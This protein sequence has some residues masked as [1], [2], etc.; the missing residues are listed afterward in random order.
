MFGDILN[1]RREA[2]TF[3]KCINGQENNY[4]RT[5]TNNNYKQND[6]NS[7]EERLVISP[8]DL[9]DQYQS[10]LNKINENKKAIN[11]LMMITN[12]KVIYSVRKSKIHHSNQSLFN[13][14]FVIEGN[15]LVHCL[16]DE[17]KDIFYELINK[18]RSVICCRCTPIQKSNIVEFIKQKSGQICLAIGDGGN[19]VN[20]I[21]KANIGVGIFGKEG[22]QAAYN[23]DYAIGQFKYLKHLLF[24]HGRYILLRNAY[25]IY[26]FFYK[27][28]LFCFPN[29]IYGF[30]T[31][32]SGTNFYDFVWFTFYTG[33]IS[34][35]PPVIYMVFE[36]DINVSFDAN[37][38]LRE[39]LP[40]IYKEFRD[41]ASFNVG[42]YFIVFALGMIHSAILFL[43][44]IYAFDKGIVDCEGRVSL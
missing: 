5:N 36:E 37:P 18:S 27:G 20:M 34:T 33:L 25:F 38:E 8:N 17:I 23:S 6:R 43:W 11:R 41:S 2:D 13:Y 4:C 32:F 1:A 22:H 26:F 39:L 7:Q 44:S 28:I 21:K 10:E 15:A 12:L 40:D 31:G 24:Y 30:Y 35:A 29:F 42:K 3:I 19:D 9:Y 16:S 14:G